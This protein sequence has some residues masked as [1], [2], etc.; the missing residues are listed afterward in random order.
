LSGAEFPSIGKN[1]I[2]LKTLYKENNNLEA[3]YLLGD[4]GVQL[5][6]AVR[7]IVPRIGRIEVGDK[8]GQ[9]S[10]ASAQIVRIYPVMGC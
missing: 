5:D 8:R 3:I 7:K 1:T 6:G 2:T 10:F 9:K 4:F